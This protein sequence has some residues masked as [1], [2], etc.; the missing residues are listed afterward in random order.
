MSSDGNGSGEKHAVDHGVSVA[1]DHHQIH[2]PAVKVGHGET[3]KAEGAQTKAVYN[4]SLLPFNG[5][6]LKVWMC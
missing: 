3:A 5:G 6:L 1:D 4:V 2:Y